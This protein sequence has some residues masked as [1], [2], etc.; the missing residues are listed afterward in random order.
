MDAVELAVSRFDK[1]HSCSQAIFSAYSEQFG[2]EY[3]TAVKITAGFGGGMARMAKTC[4]AVT[5]AI[6]VLGLKC[7]GPDSE[8]REKT[9]KLVQEFA[10]GFKR[11]NG[12]LE[13]KDLLGCDLSKPGGHQYAKEQRLYTTVCTPIVRQAAEIL[14]ELL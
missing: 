1:D 13:C 10:E 8:S 6:M 4:G 5:G 14:D 7:G 3:D 9:Y 12:S 11:R 2:V